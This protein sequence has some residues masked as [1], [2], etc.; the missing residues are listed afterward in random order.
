MSSSC[1]AFVIGGDRGCLRLWPETSGVLS[2]DSETSTKGADAGV[3][4]GGSDLK[5]L[6]VAKELMGGG[7]ELCVRRGVDS[8]GGFGSGLRYDTDRLARLDFEK[9]GGS[10]ER[11]LS[12]AKDGCG[13]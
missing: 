7:V 6:L 11:K 12:R 13:E 9:L 4:V 10:E 2:S 1:D 3:G 5:L 8:P